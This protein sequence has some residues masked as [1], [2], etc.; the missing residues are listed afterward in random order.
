[1]HAPD[2]GHKDKGGRL[3]S[4]LGSAAAS[5]AWV[6]DAGASLRQL[7]FTIVPGCTPYLSAHAMRSGHCLLTAS[8]HIID[9]SD[10]N[11]VTAVACGV[12]LPVPET[13]G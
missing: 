7:T 1:M 11:S 2:T 8:N 10:I 4:I 9:Y 13:E 6:S 5:S 12:L 3:T